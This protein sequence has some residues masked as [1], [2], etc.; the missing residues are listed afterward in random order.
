MTI[1]LTDE[2]SILLTLPMLHFSKHS[3]QFPTYIP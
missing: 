2:Q 1:T 3:Y